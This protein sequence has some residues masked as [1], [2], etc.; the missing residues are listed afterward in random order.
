MTPDGSLKDIPLDFDKDHYLSAYP[1]VRDAVA[2]GRITSGLE[3]FRR[4][5]RAEGRRSMTGA[6]PA[7]TEQDRRDRVG[8]VWSVNPEAVAG[9]YGMA[10]P[11]VRARSMRSPPV[12][13]LRWTAMAS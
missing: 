11:M 4:W 1:D 13:I 12:A 5:G 8:A 7:L 9:W 2:T 3:H 6:E 10:H